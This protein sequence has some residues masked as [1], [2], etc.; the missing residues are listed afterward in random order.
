MLGAGARLAKG[1]ASLPKAMDVLKTRFPGAKN[2]DKLKLTDD[3]QV[4]NLASY[5]KINRNAFIPPKTFTKTFEKAATG[6]ISQIDAAKELGPLFYDARTGERTGENTNRVF[7]KFFNAYLENRPDDLFTEGGKFRKFKAGFYKRTM[8]P[9]AIKRANDLLETADKG[10][11][12]IPFNRRFYDAFIKSIDY[13]T[14]QSGSQR[15]RWSQAKDLGEQLKAFK[16]QPPEDFNLPKT[17]RFDKKGNIVDVANPLAGKP[18]K[19]MFDK[20]PVGEILKGPARFQAMR[21]MNVGGKWTTVGQQIKRLPGVDRY[22]EPI[23]KAAPKDSL[24]FPITSNLYQLD[25]KVPLRFGG[26]N[27]K[28]NLRLIIQG[29][30]TGP[31]L[32]KGMTAVDDVVKSK[33][34]FEDDVFGKTIN[35]IDAVIDGDFAAADKLKKDIFTMQNNFKITNPKVDFGIGEPHVLVKTKDGAERVK[36]VDYKKVSSKIKQDLKKYLITYSNSPNKNKSIEESARELW[37]R[38]IPF[39]IMYGG[40]LPKKIGRELHEKKDGGLINDNLTDTIP[41]T[42][43]PMSKG[44]PL[45]DPQE[46]IDRQN[47]QLG[48]F[49]NLF[50]TAG[51]LPR[52]VARVGDMIKKTGK[53]EKATDIAVSQ[54]VED[55]PAMFLQTV[56]EIENMPDASNMNANQWLGTIKNKPGVSPTELDE[57][58]LEA[59]LTNISK[60]DPKRKLSK[61]ELLETYS[62]E[63]PK[64]DMDMAMAE[65]VSRGADDI[66]KMLTA[67]RESRHPRH[68][69]E[70]LDVLSNDPRLITALHQPP[71][72]ATG[73]RIRENIINVMRGTN[74][75]VGVGDNAETVSLLKPSYHKSSAE[76]HKGQHFKEMWES[77]FPK[78]FHGTN[79]IVKRDHMNVLKNLVPAEDVTQLAKAKNIPEEEAFNQLYQALNIFDRQVMTADVPIPFWTKK[80]LYRLGD[81]S[82]GRGFFFKS[83]KTPAHEGAQFIPGGSG[84]GELKFYFNF[85]HGSVRSAEKA[86][87]S[88]HF[89]GEKFGRGPLTDSGNA[90]FGWGRFSE[91]IDES[92]RKI[93]MMEEIQSDLHQQVAQKGYKYAPRLDKSDVLVEMGEFAKQLDNK[94]QTLEST[95]LRKDNILQLPKAER[96]L[97]ANV[98]E[99]KNIEKTMKKLITDVNKLKKKV[100]EQKVATGKT[101]Q[102]HPDAPFKKS[103]NYAKVFMQGLMKM[104]A[105]KGYDGVAL[106]TGKMKKQYGGIPKGGNKFYDEIGVKAMRRI[107]KKSGFNFT[108]TTITDGSGYTWEKIPLIEMRNVNTGKPILGESTIPVYKKGGIVNSNVVR[109]YN[110]Y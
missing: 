16:G 28:S 46:S 9:I 41:P 25:H 58:G 98:A 36:Y 19:D 24:G 75:T 35:M 12:E 37:E 63:M 34:A 108:D 8:S 47:F 71:Q 5:G 76:L 56:N 61:T 104:A 11:T 22:L 80:M 55:K 70:D 51:K 57:F 15:E 107:A 50:R 42:G 31:Q 105:D 72:D 94:T 93:L 6:E 60:A 86:Y 17:F 43:G 99:L 96:E 49:A 20:T 65:P 33:S 110:G 78:I 26:T 48:G 102:V 7:Q 85:D 79:E 87:D 27:D 97:P 2:L 106:S 30:H 88:G 44:I 3:S 38:Y 66:T 101:G 53:A 54:A 59:L 67:V 64:I 90:P 52:A 39:I 74:K 23:K 109:G 103:E 21:L 10:G 68:D 45:L 69:L 95:R 92:G 32:E 18:R 91:R 82:E 89:S 4:F 84:Y 13:K 83:K 73:M 100:E 81:M 1:I 77:S 14:R 62:K 40:K 29:Q